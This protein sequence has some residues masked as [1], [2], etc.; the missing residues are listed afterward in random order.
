MLGALYKLELSEE[1]YTVILAKTAV[2]ALEIATSRPIDLIV[3][4]MS[5]CVQD[6]DAA[7]KNLISG[8]NIP[9]ILN[10]G[11]H[12]HMIQGYV[13]NR[14]V[15]VLKS[16][17]LAMLK[18]KIKIMLAQREHA[19]AGK[20]DPPAVPASGPRIQQAHGNSFFRAAEPGRFECS[21]DQAAH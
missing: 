10:T 12:F 5:G 16:S 13:S 3:T 11:Y 6:A 7:V 15:H 21:H 20:K 19:A 2:Q 1:G 14:I 4:A 8:V 18:E 9:V 17:N